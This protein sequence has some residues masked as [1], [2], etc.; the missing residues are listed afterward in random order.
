MRHYKTRRDESCPRLQSHLATTH[1]GTS[2]DE[3][4]VMTH[5]SLYGAIKQLV[6]WRQRYH[7]IQ[8][9]ISTG[10]NWTQRQRQ[11][12]ELPSLSN[13]YTRPS[14]KPPYFFL[15]WVG[16]RWASRWWVHQ[17]L[18]NVHP[19]K[20]LLRPIFLP[21][22]LVILIDCNTFVPCPTGWAHWNNRPGQQTLPKK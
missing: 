2:R 9:Q 18:L 14:E 11:D 17:F 6:G 8:Y 5:D 15:R 21:T 20:S 3:S 13:Y 10:S 12:M 16:R 1:P 22:G 19:T 4:R 7:T